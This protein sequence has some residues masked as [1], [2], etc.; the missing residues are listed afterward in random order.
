MAVT[1]MGAF[2]SNQ[3]GGESLR[4]LPS[5][6]SRSY[7]QS[8]HSR[9]LFALGYHIRFHLSPPFA[10]MTID[11][12]WRSCKSHKVPRYWVAPSANA[13]SPFGGCAN[14]DSARCWSTTSSPHACV[15]SICS[16]PIERRTL[17]FELHTHPNRLLA[18]ALAAL[19]AV[20][21]CRQ[22]SAVGAPRPINRKRQEALES[23]EP[24]GL[25]ASVA[26]AR[27]GRNSEVNYCKSWPSF[28]HL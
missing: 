16:D 2:A 7:T 20:F 4:C 14:A 12:R 18:A 10:R 27:R 15:I 26:A 11:V 5:R 3:T 22:T 19:L 9:L 24:L 17:F 23:A 6:Y 25:E 21:S 13:P 1:S 28:L 8:T